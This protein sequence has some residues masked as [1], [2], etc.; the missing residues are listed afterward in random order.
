MFVA[1]P[2]GVCENTVMYDSSPRF[3][4][5]PVR[6][7]EHTALGEVTVA[8]YLQDGFLQ[9]PEDPYADFLRDVGSRAAGAEVLVAAEGGEVL[10]GVTL[11]PPGS[12]LAELAG[13]HEAEIRSLAVAPAG[14]GRGLGTALARACVERAREAEAKRVVLCSQQEMRAAHRLYG[15]L[16]FERAPELDWRPRPET[17]LWGFALEL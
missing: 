6:D 16:G 5:R 13:E 14:R 8:A 7:T 1:L 9:G 10:G 17:L 3:A 4:I 15:R 12:P 2:A 11:V